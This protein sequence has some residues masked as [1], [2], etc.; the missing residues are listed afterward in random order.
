[1]KLTRRLMLAAFFSFGTWLVALNAGASRL[2][3]RRAPDPVDTPRNYGFDSDEVK[4]TS[5]DHVRLTGWWIPADNAVGTI[6]MCPGQE[7]SMDGDTRQMVPLHD[8]GFNV[9]MF[10]FRAHG[11]SEGEVVSMGM[12][13][14]EDLLGALDFLM[15]HYGVEKDGGLGFS[16][17]AAVALVAAAHADR[18]C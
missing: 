13:E 4:F 18:I 11:R 12:Y 15:E 2:M 6:V 1:M 16:M 7:G 14:K 9:L 5:R 3:R 8:S 17:G 10:D